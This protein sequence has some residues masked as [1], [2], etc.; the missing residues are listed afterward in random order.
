MS[1]IKQ[2]EHVETERRG[3]VLIV[4]LSNE[5]ARNSLSAEMR[6]SLRTIVREIEDDRSVRSVYLCGKGKSFCSG[7]DL[8][9]LTE[10]SAPWAVHRR[11]RHMKSLLPPL[12][13]LD[14]PVVCG[15]HGHVVGGGMGF[16][17][18]ADVIVAAE[19]TQFMADFFRLGVVPDCLMLHTLPRLIGL[20]RT[21]NFLFTNGT[22]DAR[23]SLDLGLVAKVV[24]DEDL[25]AEGLALAQSLA[26]APSEIM[27]L[28]KQ[29]L[30][31]SFESSLDDIML[32]EDLGQALAMSGAE[33][34]EGLEALVARRKPDFQAAAEADP[35]SDG[36]PPSEP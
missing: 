19:S 6:E 4:R 9:M 14:R 5:S 20:A 32:Y 27:G 16:A 7:G 22:F 17:L 2:Y 12:M 31:R 26:E 18:A 28:A 3:A 36:L 33:F 23:Q 8:K 29:I 25:E 35:T 30:M 1:T 13:S 10:A 24:S 34:K 21:R 11:F 15:V